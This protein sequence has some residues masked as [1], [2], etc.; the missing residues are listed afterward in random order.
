MNVGVSNL[1]MHILQKY[2]RIFLLFAIVNG[3]VTSISDCEV[4]SSRRGRVM[5][6]VF[7][8]DW[9]MTACSFGKLG[10]CVQ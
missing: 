8:L 3:I 7:L 1:E 6:E 5:P 2:K 9:R 4:T 10:I